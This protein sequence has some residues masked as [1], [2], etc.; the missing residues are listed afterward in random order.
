VPRIAGFKRRGPLVLLQTDGRD[1][2][3]TRIA[4]MAAT[5]AGEDG[6]KAAFR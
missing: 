1:A 3:F 5:R 2:L 6:G 4:D